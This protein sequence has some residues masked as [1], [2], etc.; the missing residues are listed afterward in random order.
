MPEERGRLRQPIVVI[1]GHVDSGKCV[2]SDTPIQLG[3]GRIVQARE[4]FEAFKTGDPVERPDGVTYAAEGLSLLSIDETGRAAPRPASYVWKL[5]ADRLVE[6]QTKAGYSVKTTPEHRFLVML[7]SGEIEYRE[8]RKLG[9][10]D[11]VLVP[12]RTFV[13]QN[14]IGEIKGAILARLS[15]GF[16]LSVSPGFSEEVRRIAAGRVKDFG[17]GLGDRNFEDHLRKR[18]F[19]PTIFRELA[20]MLRLAPAEAYDAI[21]ELKLASGEWHGGRARRPIS[22]PKDNEGFEALAY[23]VGLLYGDGVAGSAYLSNTSLHLI[24]EFRKSLGRAFSVG[25]SEAWRRASHIVAHHGGKTL[26]T[27]L[28]EA[29]EYPLRDKTRS[30]DVPEL[31]SMMPDFLVA[32]FL[33][34]FFDAEGFVQEG[35]N[36]GVGCESTMLMRRLPMLLQR[37]GCLAYAGRRSHEREVIIGGE[38]FVS[39]FNREVGFREPR[40]REAALQRGRHAE[41]NRVFEPTPIP[42]RFLKS[43]REGGE[44]VWDPRYQ[45][46][47]FEPYSRPSRGVLAS[48]R[49][50]VPSYESASLEKTLANF[51]MV[52]VTGLLEDEGD[53]EVFDFTVD[54]THNF[55]AN[56]M[57]IHNTTLSDQLRGTTVQAREVGGI[58]QEIGASFFPIEALKQICGSLLDRAGG[59]LQ[60]PGLLLIDTPGH[61]VFSNLRLRGGS[62]ADIAILVVDVMKGLENQTLESIDILKQRHVPFLVAL[63]KIDMIAGWK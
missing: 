6:V 28:H 54:G 9:I 43:V 32:A 50:A 57:V 29:F 2:S 59:E 39:A 35:R 20:K 63:N 22:L 33:Q 8:A 42:G 41:T 30:L 60:I 36:I 34:G 7:P 26:S 24:E 48:L 18:R 49:Q 15:D 61:A 21:I 51:C 5:H 3:D 53:F 16:L 19:R 44:V 31:V 38:T 45:L 27:F 37:F 23:V 14:D 46:T 11:S 40:K 55:I 52:Q 13:H 58:T 47:S 56:C 62:A 17:R 1:L 10:G 25:A 12:A 4:V